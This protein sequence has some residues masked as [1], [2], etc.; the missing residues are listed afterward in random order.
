MSLRWAYA[1]A[2]AA[3]ALGALGA[4]PFLALHSHLSAIVICFVYWLGMILADVASLDLAARATPK[5]VEAMGYAL[6]ISFWNIGIAVSDV[7]GSWMYEHWKVP[8]SGLVWVN[9]GTTAAVLLVVPFLPGRLMSRKEG[10]AMV[11]A[12]S[13]KNE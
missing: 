4:L 2:V 5:G 10:E 7:T 11:E 13:P 8:F 3:A 12:S 1:L 6:M 9:A